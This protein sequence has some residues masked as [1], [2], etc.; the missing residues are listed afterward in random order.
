M[1]DMDF[2]VILVGVIATVLIVG[3]TSMIPLAVFLDYKFRD[4]VDRLLDRR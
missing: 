1:A 4:R 3:A 2:D